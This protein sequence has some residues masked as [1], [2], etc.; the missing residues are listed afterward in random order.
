M[1][2][3]S[4]LI[5]LLWIA[6]LHP[7]L[8]A[9]GWRADDP[10]I[11]D[12]ALAA[13][14]WWQPF[15]DGAFWRRLSPSN[16]TPWLTLS[17]G[18]DLRLAGARPGLFYA[19]QLTALWLASWALQRLL[20]RPAGAVVAL[21]TTMVFVAGPPALDVGELL[22]TRHYIEGLLFALLAIHA[23]M[24]AMVAQRSRAL[25]WTAAGALLYLLACTAK[26]IY[27][28]LVGVLP[29]VP[30]GK[31]RQRLHRLLP[32]VAVALGYVLWRRH[33]LGATL[34][35]Y[36]DTSGWQPVGAMA[37]VLDAYAGLPGL[38]FGPAWPLVTALT[39]A[40]AAW[41]WQRCR[42]RLF[43]ASTAAAL[44]APLAPLALSPGIREADRY[45]LLPWLGVCVA[46]GLGL[47]RTLV[48]DAPSGSTVQ[49]LARA[50]TLRWLTVPAAALAAGA[51]LWQ[52]HRLYE[53]RA[54]VHAE[55]DVQGRFILGAGPR[56]AFIPTSRLSGG[57]WYVR[58]LSALRLR[59]GE[60]GPTALL[61]GF[62]PPVA[63]QRL[64][65]YDPADRAMH[66]I[67]ARAD[68]ML[69]MLSADTHRPLAA[70]FEVQG[71]WLSWS[72]GPEQDGAYYLASP[73]LGRLPVGR[74]GSTRVPGL[75]VRFQ[76]QHLAADG[77]L[78]RSDEL[79]LE[80]GR[81]VLQWRRP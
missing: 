48:R 6:A 54:S 37:A 28:P 9:A 72:L 10:A 64:W 25:C 61:A 26:E 42:H 22:M 49:A 57:F 38:V 29:F 50:R 81:A 73:T 66:D 8:P 52:S 20:L 32:F 69:A 23:W 16:L 35:G 46:L 58:G 12:H 55:F 2:R 27:V 4:P 80:S 45:L 11:L 56:D 77:V 71:G 34:G 60:A 65:V 19:H 1:Q 31:W 75:P 39:I 33:M 14:S 62:E 40:A 21:G 5:L 74:V 36:A 3:C 53:A 76:V 51:A 43:I 78:T 67:T 59:A 7:S 68:A 13:G 79:T 41:G 30:F 70:R 44:L 18:L 47:A 63:M 17:F 24:R 15:V